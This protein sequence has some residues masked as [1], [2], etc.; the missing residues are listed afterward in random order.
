MPADFVDPIVKLTSSHLKAWDTSSH[1]KAWGESLANS[2]HRWNAAK[3]NSHLLI[4]CP[5]LPDGPKHYFVRQVYLD[6]LAHVK[7][8]LHS[9][10]RLL[11]VMGQTGAGTTSAIDHLVACLCAVDIPVKVIEGTHTTYFLGDKTTTVR[12]EDRPD[13]ADFVQTFSTRPTVTIYDAKDF[14]EGLR[15][16][17]LEGNNGLVVFITSA[18]MKRVQEVPKDIFAAYFI[19]PPWSTEEVSIHGAY[20]QSKRDEW[21]TELRGRWNA[22]REKER[23]E[24]EAGDPS[25]LAGLVR[26]G[27]AS[28]G[29]GLG[30]GEDELSEDQLWQEYRRSR[31]LE[32]P[33]VFCSSFDGYDVVALAEKFGTDA[34]KLF[35]DWPV[36]MS[37]NASIE[38][39]VDDE[40]KSLV[41][42]VADQVGQLTSTT[43]EG[44]PHENFHVVFVLTA[45]ESA[46]SVDVRLQYGRKPKIFYTF[47]T[48]HLKRLFLQAVIRK[49]GASRL[50][51]S[52]QFEGIHELQA[53]LFENYAEGNS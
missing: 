15:R 27:S 31:V 48:D 13:D 1:L 40:I 35:R 16:E 17:N 36:Y 29:D 42:S 6:L 4:D 10:R 44:N 37:S 18:R 11:I 22:A 21:E 43:P 14:N 9:L 49:H 47:I 28:K 50:R 23:A 53:V 26:K 41:S 20:L 3:P 25:I 45:E 51:L 38:Q 19:P 30:G 12:R 46:G 7:R 32:Q 8:E 34:R 33:D 52:R 39:T 5:H 24:R 2:R